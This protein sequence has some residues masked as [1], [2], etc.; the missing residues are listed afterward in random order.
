MAKIIFP[1]AADTI[2]P[3]FVTLPGSTI[4]INLTE[5]QTITTNPYIIK[6]KPNDDNGIQRVEFYI[7]GTLICTAT[8]PDAGGVY[9]C[10]W[11]TSK[12]HSDIRVIAYDNSGNPSIALT[13]STVVDPSLYILPRTGMNIFDY[14]KYIVRAIFGR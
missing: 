11:D 5:G 3:T 4:P 8:T 1:E 10:S 6:V 14:I 13:R 12:Y 9:S 2:S 7:D